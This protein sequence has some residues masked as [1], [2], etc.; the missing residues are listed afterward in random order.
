MS[1]YNGIDQPA[2]LSCLITGYTVSM[3]KLCA[4]VHQYNAYLRLQQNDKSESLLRA[5]AM[6]YFLL[7]LCYCKLYHIYKT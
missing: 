3:K 6:W 2:H 1:A 4:L 5:Y 7:D